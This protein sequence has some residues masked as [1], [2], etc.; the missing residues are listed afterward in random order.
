[1]SGNVTKVIKDLRLGSKAN[2]L[3]LDREHIDNLSK[4]KAMTTGVIVSTNICECGAN[5]NPDV[6]IDTQKVFVPVRDG[7]SDVIMMER[8]MSVASQIQR[9]G[10]VGRR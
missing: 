6:V 4:A 3:P 10:R 7:D 1:M 9:R 5:L 8:P 2:A